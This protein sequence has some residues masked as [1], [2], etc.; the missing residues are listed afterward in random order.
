MTIHKEG[1]EEYLVI[2]LYH[3]KPPKKIKIDLNGPLF[4]SIE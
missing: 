3:L 2:N 4:V 1:V